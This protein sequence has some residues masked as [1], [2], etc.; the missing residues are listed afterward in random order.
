MNLPITHVRMEREATGSWITYKLD[1]PETRNLDE[2]C[3][4]AMPAWEWVS[5]AMHDPDNESGDIVEPWRE[6]TWDGRTWH[7]PVR[8][9]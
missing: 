5:G 6:E 7:S 8:W 1:K 4:N 9:D 3:A 2:V